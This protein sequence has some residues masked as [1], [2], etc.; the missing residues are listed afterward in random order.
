MPKR[1]II[2]A[3]GKGTR[4]RPYTVVLPKPLMPIGEFPILEVIV[5]QLVRHGFDHITM[6]VNH[7]A[8]IIKAFFQ[9][10]AKWGVKIDYSLEDK[11]LSTMAPLR[12]IHDLPE[13]FLVMNGDILT[14]LSYSNI[15]DEHVS[16]N[17]IFTISAYMREQKVDYGVLEMGASN[18]LTGF[19]EKPSNEYLVSMGVYMASRRILDFIPE[20]KSYGFDN[21]MHDLMAAGQPAAVRRFDGYWLDIGRPDDYMQA[22]EEFDQMK[23]R[24]LG[25]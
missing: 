21:L 20:G 12:L 15:F 11:P 2:L 19:R 14:D 18:H 4:L 16:K 23:Q 1:A 17:N 8:E 10:G 5:R 9:G 6:A 7:Q 3:G 24:F 13:N 22:I 25:E